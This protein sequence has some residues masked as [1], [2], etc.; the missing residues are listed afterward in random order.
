[1]IAIF[2]KHKII[3]KDAVQEPIWKKLC[4]PKQMEFGLIVDI[5]CH[6]E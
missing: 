1:M 3:S 2:E 4:M 6:M 5:N